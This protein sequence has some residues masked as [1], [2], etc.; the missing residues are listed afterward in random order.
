MASNYIKKPRKLSYLSNK[1]LLEEIA[2]SRQMNRPTYNLAKAFML[3]VKRYATRANW[4]GYSYND[5]MQSNALLALCKGWHNFN[6]DRSDNPFAYFTTIVQNAFTAHLNN[7]HK[8]R[9]IRDT[10]LMS[11]G[12]K[13][14][15]A[16]EG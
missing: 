10:I 4:I 6:A 13:P 7:E 5:D 15:W 8:L 11:S 9:D 16:Y 12:V 2:I 14:S 1:V 3:L